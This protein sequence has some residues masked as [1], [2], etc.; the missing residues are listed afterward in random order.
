M[1]RRGRRMS[2][3][4]LTPTLG[5]RSSEEARE[6]ASGERIAIPPIVA[7]SKASSVRSLRIGGTIARSQMTKRSRRRMMMMIKMMTLQS[8]QMRERIAPT[9]SAA[10]TRST[11]ARSALTACGGSPHVLS[12]P[13]TMRPMTMMIIKTM[14]MMTMR[15]MIRLVLCMLTSVGR[16]C[17][18]M[19]LENGKSRRSVPRSCSRRCH[20]TTSFNCCMALP[21]V[22]ASLA[23]SR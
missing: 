21:G 12:Q 5:R 20:S 15:R 22:W 11:H 2:S 17:L 9:A 7:P 4:H 1:P 23:T 6:V 19:F 3:L 13:P 10:W 18:P 16:I 14:M 8:A